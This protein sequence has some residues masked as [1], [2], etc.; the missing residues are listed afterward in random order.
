MVYLCTYDEMFMV[1]GGC[2]QL[3]SLDDKSWHADI[4]RRDLTSIVSNEKAIVSTFIFKVSF[5]T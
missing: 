4:P 1:L 5:Q 2:I 3:I